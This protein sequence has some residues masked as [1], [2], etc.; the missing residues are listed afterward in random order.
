MPE[1]VE[2]GVEGL[3]EVAFFVF[4][5]T[6]GDFDADVPGCDDETWHAAGAFLDRQ[7]EPGWAE[8][9]F[10]FLAGAIGAGDAQ[11]AA[12]QNDEFGFAHAVGVE[13]EEEGGEQEFESG[14]A[15]HG[16]GSEPDEDGG[17]G[18]A[19]GADR[20]EKPA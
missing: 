8:G 14:E 6:A 2:G 18:A 16:P 19:H 5:E 9:A 10:A 13:A 11:T 3:G 12:G 4:A 17:G 15:A 1:V 20:D 7:R